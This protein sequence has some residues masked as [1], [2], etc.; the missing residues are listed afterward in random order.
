MKCYIFKLEG[1]TSVDYSLDRCYKVSLPR[2]EISKLAISPDNK[3]LACILHNKEEP[4]STSTLI[5][6]PLSELIQIGEKP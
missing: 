4:Q 3:D 5:R 1:G 6:A 2:S